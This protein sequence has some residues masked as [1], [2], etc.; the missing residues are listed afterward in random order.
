ML[1]TTLYAFIP[2][3]AKVVRHNGRNAVDRGLARGVSRLQRHT[4]ARRIGSAIR[5]ADS[6]TVDALIVRG[7]AITGNAEAIR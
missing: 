5:A 4:I 6:G 2:H 1:G 7:L 3:S